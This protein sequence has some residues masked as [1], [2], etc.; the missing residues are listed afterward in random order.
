MN[1]AAAAPL[2]LLVAF[3]LLD[4]G[5]ALAQ[6][7]AE[8]PRPATPEPAPSASLPDLVVTRVEVP[9]F[10][11]SEKAPQGRLVVQ[12]KNVGK[13]PSRDSAIS[14]FLW[15]AAGIDR[16]FELGPLVAGQTG[17]GRSD[18]LAFAKLWGQWLVVVVDS[19]GQNAEASELNNVFGLQ[20]PAEM[21]VCTPGQVSAGWAII[22]RNPA[23]E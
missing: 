12:V 13:A 20:L 9:C 11:P 1:A 14:L 8:S 23:A 4:A 15:P 2:S 7:P 10:G 21:P 19:K 3:L 6:V 16:T 5:P 18:V 22:F 17:E